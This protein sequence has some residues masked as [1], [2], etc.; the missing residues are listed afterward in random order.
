MT[1]VLAYHKNNQPYNYFG[2]I[3]IRPG[4]LLVV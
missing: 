1:Q 3:N 4:G 2:I